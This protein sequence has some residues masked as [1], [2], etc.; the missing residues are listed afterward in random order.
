MKY[1]TKYSESDLE[2]INDPDYITAV[3]HTW[4]CITSGE[5]NDHVIHQLLGELVG[6]GQATT[7]IMFKDERILIANDLSFL[8][9]VAMTFYNKKIEGY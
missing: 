1:V 6:M 3:C 5:L 8:V 2:L 4:Q 7:L 9:S